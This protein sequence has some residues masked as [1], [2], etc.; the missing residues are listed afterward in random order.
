MLPEYKKK[1]II[2]LTLQA[3]VLPIACTVLYIKDPIL[4]VACA[5]ISLFLLFRAYLIV[6][7]A[8]APRKWRF[9]I[10]FFGP[11]AAVMLPDSFPPPARK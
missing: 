8:N 7:K 9:A 1:T 10:L 2:L 6:W 3:I 11:L 4:N 5:G